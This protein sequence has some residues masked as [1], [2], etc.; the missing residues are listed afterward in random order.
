MDG[1]VFLAMKDLILIACFT[2]KSF[3]VWFSRMK[4]LRSTKITAHY[5]EKTMSKCQK[6]QINK[7]N[8]HFIK[9]AFWK[10][11]AGLNQPE[12]M[13]RLQNKTFDI[14]FVSSASWMI[15]LAPLLA[16]INDDKVFFSPTNILFMKF[17]LRI[18]FWLRFRQLPRFFSLLIPT[19]SSLVPFSTTARLTIHPNLS[20]LVVWVIFWINQNNIIRVLQEISA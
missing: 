10:C 19:L 9:K 7:L 13:R 15:L 5:H 2:F 6:F 11:A 16:L 12:A 3:L 20:R 14:K 1:K 17:L 8:N 4:R 18:K